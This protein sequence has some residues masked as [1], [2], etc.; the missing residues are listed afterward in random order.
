MTAQI[1]ENL[2]YK[3]KDYSMCTQPLDVYLNICDIKFESTTRCTALW[4]G[5]VGSWEIIDDRL[6][7]IGISGDTHEYGELKLTTFFPSFPERVFAHWY[8]GTIRLPD[9]KMLEYV[10]MGY[11][12]TYEKDILIE[13]KKGVVVKEEIK[14]NGISNDENAS[15]GYGVAAMTCFAN[16]KEE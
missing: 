2:L 10:H 4:R 11:G 8:N 6:Y 13:I 16:N 3:G 12:S 7:L 15:E 1:S 14:I 9:G 5:Y